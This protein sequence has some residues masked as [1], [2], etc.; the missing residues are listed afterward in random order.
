[1]ITM[2]VPR[3]ERCIAPPRVFDRSPASLGVA[4]LAGLLLSGCSRDPGE[5]PTDGLD[6]RYITSDAGTGCARPAEGC[7]CDPDQPPID[8]YLEPVRRDGRLMCSRGTRYCRQGLW[9]SCESVETYELRGGPGIAALVTGPSECNP[10]DPACAV[11]RDVPSAGDLPGRSTG[12]EYDP[13][14]GGIHIEPLE[15]TGM[16][17]LPDSDGDGIPDIADECVGPGA[18]TAADGSCYGDT[19]FYHELPY[20]GPAEID[21]LDVSVQVRTADIYFLMDTTGSMGGEIDNLRTGL[22]SGTFAGCS[23]GI[24]GAIRCTIPDAWFG[25]GYHDD[26]PVSPYGSSVDRVYQNLQDITGNLAATETA[27][28]NLVLHNG[29]DGPES[30]TQA[31]WAIATGGGLGP[32]LSAR[33][34]SGT[35]W[36]YP[37]F[38]AGTIPIVILFT[39]APFHNGPSGNG[40]GSF[41]SGVTLPPTTAVTGNEA[42]ASAYDVGD[43]AIS[44]QGFTGNTCGMIRDH[45]VGCGSSAR[46]AVFRFTV[47]TTSVIRISAEGSSYDTAIGLRSSTGTNIECDDDDGPGTTSYIER[48]LAPGTYYVVVTGWS[49]SCG[50]YRL[51]IGG[52]P[53]LYPVTWAQ[54]VSALNSAGVRVITIHSGDWYYSEPYGLSDARALADATGSLSSSGSRYVFSIPSNGTGL[55]TAV[56]DA[57]VDLAN[58]HRMDIGARAVD[59]PATAG[60]DERGFVDAITAVG[61]GPGSCES[62]SGGHTFVQCLP[63]TNVDFTI[64]FRNDFVMPTTVA[65]VFDFWIE[66]VGNGTFVLERVPVRIVVPSNVPTYPPSG[67]YWRDYDSTLFCEGTERPDWNDLTWE[68]VDLPAGTSIRWEIRA[69]ATLAGLATA[70][71][72]TFTTPPTTSPVD[73][74][75][76]LTSASIG[77]YLPY[78]RV[79]AVL[80]ASPDRE[81][82]PTLRSFEVRYTCIPQE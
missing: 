69:S 23:G 13:G 73:I 30:Q 56:V 5:L 48:T 71:P 40:Y 32:Y 53:A 61:W 17:D 46:D 49:T 20:G 44:W 76:R 7:A 64:A 81:R 42:I 58:Y 47:S 16:P 24:I 10:C 51:S 2:V 11:S 15:T 38:R 60:I 8:C 57:V 66:V 29:N 12:V 33:S 65:Q 34:C 74:G 82:S 78:L 6:P 54:T 19:F 77:N 79:T 80:L 63:G 68:T 45:D 25:V 37:C 67:S 26:Y 21:P 35:R 70:T 4:L 55:S 28:G 59:N 14:S 41:G 3:S 52:A 22:R 18:L 43:A 36:G 9:A 1:M 39:D 62:T 75:A 27:V 72:T 31:L 50:D